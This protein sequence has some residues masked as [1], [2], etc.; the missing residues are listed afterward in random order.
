MPKRKAS[1]NLPLQLWPLS[2]NGTWTQ[3]VNRVCQCV[4]VDFSLELLRVFP[5]LFLM[6]DGCRDRGAHFKAIIACLFD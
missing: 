3:T 1:H 4:W 6:S 5:F 2:A